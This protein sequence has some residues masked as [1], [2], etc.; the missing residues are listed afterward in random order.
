MVMAAERRTAF[1]SDARLKAKA[2]NAGE[3]AVGNG[4]IEGYAAVWGNLDLVGEIMQRGCFA[5]SIAQVVPAG[6]V[7]LMVVHY[8]DGGD[9]VEVIGRVTEAREDDYG[10]WIHA[11]LSAATIAQDARTKVLEGLISGLSVGYRDIRATLAPM[12]IGDAEQLVTQHQECALLEVTVTGRPANPR[13]QITDAKSLV[14]A[15]QKSD[16]APQGTQT[17]APAGTVEGKSTPAGTPEPPA[18]HAIRRDLELRRKR[19]NLA[20]GE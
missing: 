11:D 18:S 17:P 8:R 9:T 19:W 5:R 12:K 14:P 3:P 20:H 13:A 10:L 6:K 1:V 2:I 7:P 16:E 15:P 4:W